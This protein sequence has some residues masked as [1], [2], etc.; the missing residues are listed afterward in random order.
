MKGLKITIIILLIVLLGI[1][2]YYYINKTNTNNNENKENNNQTSET[3]T[4]EQKE[5]N[6]EE[7]YKEI[8]N[9]YKNAKEEFEQDDTLSLEEKY[10][11][12]S[13]TLITHIIRYKETTQL[14]YT[15]YDIDNNGTKELIL[16]LKEDDNTLM[17]A[18][19]YTHNDN[20]V[21]KIYY[22]DTI[23]RG[24]LE[25]YDNGILYSTGAGSATTHYYRFYKIA[26]D[27][28]SLE[29]LENIKEEYIT[30]TEVKYYEGDTENTLDYKDSNEIL[31][32]YINNSNKLEL[33]ITNTIN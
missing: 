1:G 28:I 10:P 23:E 3:I 16:G 9:E 21:K 33:T 2:G 6:V 29:T 4:E 13:E 8:I 15:Y 12:V 22:L 14:S 25:I 7:I 31:K 5:E 11:L 30:D 26:S 19:I 20:E 18:A 32:K 24:N 27:G 17:P